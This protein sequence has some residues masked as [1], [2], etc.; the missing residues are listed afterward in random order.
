MDERC[1]F[2]L[3]ALEELLAALRRFE[4]QQAALAGQVDGLV[5][6][7]ELVREYHDQSAVG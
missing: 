3:E 5:V 6:E 1:P 4:M 2:T 7:G